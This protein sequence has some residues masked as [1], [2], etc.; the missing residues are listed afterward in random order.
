[1]IIRLAMMAADRLRFDTRA[2]FDRDRT[3][4]CRFEQSQPRRSFNRFQSDIAGKSVGYDNMCLAAIDF[5]RLRQSQ[6]PC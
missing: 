1:V 6:I 3:G 5:I 4:E 2:D